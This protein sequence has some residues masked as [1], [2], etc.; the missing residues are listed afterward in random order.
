MSSN[1]TDNLKLSQW[2]LS[3]PVLMEDFNEDNRK[4]DAAVHSAQTTADAA[5]STANIAQTELQTSQSTVNT[6]IAAA[7][8][9]SG[10]EPTIASGTTEGY[11]RGDKTWQNFRAET[12]ATPLTGL[13]AVNTEFSANDTII[14]AFGKAMGR[15]NQRAPIHTPVFQGLPMAPTQPQAQNNDRIA[16]T[17]FVH[18]A[19]NNVTTATGHHQVLINTTLATA[20]RNVE[21]NLTNINLSQFIKLIIS[22]FPPSGGADDWDLLWWRMNG[23]TDHQQRFELSWSQ[24]AITNVMADGG[25]FEVLLTPVHRVYVITAAHN[26]RTSPLVTPS[27]LNTIQLLR[28]SA[29]TDN[30]GVG[31]RFLVLGVRR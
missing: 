20:N 30:F 5:L 8:P 6:H 15:I 13:T 14:Q 10:S 24:T 29:G 16:T 18:T 25:Y 11:W 3:D 12:R 9:H 28:N 22:Y 1:K 2:V 17:A 7:N 23:N 19:V 26:F 31:S 27:N 21:L 4:T